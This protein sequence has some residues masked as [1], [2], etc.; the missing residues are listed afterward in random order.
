MKLNQHTLSQLFQQQANQPEA[1]L[2]ELF[3][4]TEASDAR[5][6]LAEKLAD[7]RLACQSLQLAN[8]LKPWS[9]ALGEQLQAAQ[10]PKHTWWQPARWLVAGMAF[11][12]LALVVTPQWHSSPSQGASQ[13]DAFFAGHFDPAHPPSDRIFKGKFAPAKAATDKP[14]FKARFESPADKQV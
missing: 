12:A 1:P 3:N 14:L 6:A 4:T 9:Q 8:A 7:D 11:A 10:A 2:N 5:I 13:N